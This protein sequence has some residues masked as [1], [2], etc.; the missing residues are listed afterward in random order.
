MWNKGD[1]AR[2][3][4]D[5]GEVFE[6]WYEGVVIGVKRSDRGDAIKIQVKF[7]ADNKK[8]TFDEQDLAA[9]V[10]QWV[11]AGDLPSTQ[12]VRACG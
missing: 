10:L 1:R 4:F 3:L 11:G 8:V 5:E 2:A 6:S 9:G 7:D 12:G